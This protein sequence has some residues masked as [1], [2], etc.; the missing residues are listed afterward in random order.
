MKRNRLLRIPIFSLLCLALLATVV[1]LW[2][3]SREHADVLV[4]FSPA[5]HWEGL[6]SDR[7]GMLFF[8]SDIPWGEEKAFTLDAGTVGGEDATKI[9]DFVFDPTN[10]KW[11][12]LGFHA[13]GGTVAS[14]W[15]FSSIIVPYWALV[16]PLSLLA[17]RI[18]S[19]RITRWRRKRKG[20]CLT[21]GYDLRQSPERCPECGARPGERSDH[22]AA[23]ASKASVAVAL[24]PWLLLGIAS[25]AVFELRSRGRAVAARP[26]SPA[27]VGGRIGQLNLNDVPLESALVSLQP[28]AGARIRL[29]DLAG[30]LS[31]GDI[32]SDLRVRANLRDVSWNA[33]ARAILDA[34]GNQY[35]KDWQMW[36]AQDGSICLGEAA[37]A[38]QMVRVY[39][40]GD[41][42]DTYPESP[43][44][45]SF[46]HRDAVIGPVQSAA[47]LRQSAAEALCRLL[48]DAARSEDW[49]DNGGTIG[50]VCVVGD[51]LIVRQTPEG[52]ADTQALLA[53]MRTAG[54]DATPPPDESPAANPR[55]NLEQKIPELKLESATFESAI[56]TL[57]EMT[58]ANIVVSWNELTAANVDPKAPIK[59]HLWD[60]T[61]GQ[62]LNVVFS[63]ASHDV[64][65]G[66]DVRNNIIFVTTTDALHRNGSRLSGR[67]YD[68]RDIVDQILRYR[69]EHSSYPTT[70][71][72]P[73]TSATFVPSSEAED[74]IEDITRTLE[75]HVSPDSWK[76]NGG[77][78]GTIREF[79]GRLI[80]T[81]TPEN[82][83]KIVSVLRALRAGG[84]KE[85][86]VLSK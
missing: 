4:F 63:L 36:K 71:P 60:T 51:R 14:Q 41:L 17:L 32:P 59:L 19:S 20:Q 70:A 53:A 9:H 47:P 61:L 42:L 21:C 24:L 29:P 43:A 72:Q 79:A 1:V 33:A 26:W 7:Q 65:I 15:K 81:Q 30:S 66:S 10:E 37:K 50:D 75:D 27:T 45:D 44:N 84:D 67:L 77:S 85:G 68:V 46:L 16:T 25:A 40:V 13:A 6:A 58:H 48:M 69:R 52:H 82:H 2:A 73:A 38:P 62:A 54:P 55:A 57:R 12:F 5:G 56:D 76:D 64:S 34:T 23:G 49:R 86:T 11:K 80:I 8:G 22:A 18:F 3:R 78:D 74:A 39:A 28:A 35:L 83:R 31:N